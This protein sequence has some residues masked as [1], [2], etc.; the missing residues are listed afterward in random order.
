MKKIAITGGI[1]SGKSTVVKFIEEL[2]YKTVSA[3][4]V[5]TQ[6][7]KE[8]SFVELISKAI[9]VKPLIEGGKAVLDR[10]AVSKEVFGNQ[11]KLKLL[12]SLTHPAIIKRMFEI[13]E[14]FNGVVFYEVPLLFEASLQ[15]LFDNTIVV[16]RNITDRINSVMERDGTTE[17]AVINKINN[18]YDYNL[19]QDNKYYY[20]HNDGDMFQLKNSVVKIIGE[21]IEASI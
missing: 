9:G 13:G 1:G 15:D 19:L 21:I 18:Q 5:Y 14:S 10:K 8:E 6:L 3:D 7:L 16:K 17:Q 2:G 20:I 12:N 4:E 11:E